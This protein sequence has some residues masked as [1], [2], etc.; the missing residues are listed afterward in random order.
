MEPQYIPP[1]YFFA[2]TFHSQQHQ[3]LWLQ[4]CDNRGCSPIADPVEIKR[5][6]A[7]PLT[8]HRVPIILSWAE[9]DS[10]P[11]QFGP[12]T[13]DR[14]LQGVRQGGSFH[15]QSP[16]L[17]GRTVGSKKWVARRSSKPR[18]GRPIMKAQK[19]TRTNDKSY[20]RPN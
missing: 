15:S 6:I 2:E 18:A 1:Q 7:N 11:S 5:E 16:F 12:S 4:K 10:N 17:P 8:G 14:D 19:R 13:Y 9:S 20:W 3:L